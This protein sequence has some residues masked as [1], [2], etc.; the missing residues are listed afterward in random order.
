MT[1]QYCCL[2]TDK[3]PFV[4]FNL[5]NAFNYTDLHEQGRVIFEKT[6]I[7]EKK[8]N[9]NTDLQVVVAVP[10]PCRSVPME[11]ERIC[12]ARG[13]RSARLDMDARRSEDAAC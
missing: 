4:N 7:N 8:R 2:R 6:K 13:E 1:T 10:N 5:V 9:R 3:S 12:D 11:E